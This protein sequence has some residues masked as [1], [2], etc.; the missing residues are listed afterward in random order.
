MQA[1]FRT[2]RRR[3]LPC[4]PPQDGKTPETIAAKAETRKPQGNGKVLHRNPPSN[5]NVQITPHDP[6]FSAQG[7]G[8]SLSPGCSGMLESSSAF[9]TRQCVT[10]SGPF[11]SESY[12]HQ[13]QND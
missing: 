1:I 6:D 13:G 7:Q 2:D 11:K 9:G 12:V 5:L 10:A 3:L 4:H 8:G